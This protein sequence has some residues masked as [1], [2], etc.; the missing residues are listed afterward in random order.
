MFFIKARILSNNLKAVKLT[1]LI[2]EV[3]NERHPQSVKQLITMLREDLNLDKETILKSVLKLHAEGKIKLEDK[4]LVSQKLKSYLMISGSIWYWMILLV[5]VLT[6][7]LV[8]AISEA[9]YPW[10]YIRNAFGVIFVLFF[11]GYVFTKTLFPS[12]ISNKTHEGELERIERIVLSVGM[13]L[14]LVSIIGLLL[15]YSPWGLD[16]TTTVLGLVVFTS[17]F[18][19]IALIRDYHE[20]K[21]D[22][23]ES[24]IFRI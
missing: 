11:P 24:L 1:Q 22:L 13:S 23:K 10:I 12:I 19:T 17:V 2:V 20:K 14:A 9:F 3:I 15:Y 16:L 6:V 18:A 5:E 7:M 4:T 21:I 8:F